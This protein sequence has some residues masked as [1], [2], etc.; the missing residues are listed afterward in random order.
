MAAE[1]RIEGYEKKMAAKVCAR[2]YEEL[3]DFIE[4]V[5][6]SWG[7]TRYDACEALTDLDDFKERLM[8][9]LPFDPEEAG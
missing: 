9:V 5:R 2:L 3:D 7:T 6:A 1:W 8:K 4:E